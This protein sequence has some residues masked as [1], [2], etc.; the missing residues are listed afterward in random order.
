M[1]SL[2]LPAMTPSALIII[3]STMMLI[4][5]G[6][7]TAL[8]PSQRPTIGSGL[9]MANTRDRTRSGWAASREEAMTAV[10]TAWDRW[11]DQ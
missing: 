5:S 8:K 6:R 11:G 10:R 7:S 1:K 9:S 4:A 3:R 2:R